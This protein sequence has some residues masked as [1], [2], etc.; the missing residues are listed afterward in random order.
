MVHHTRRMNHGLTRA[1]AVELRGITR[2]FPSSS[3]GG[4]GFYSHQWNSSLSCI[5]HL[6]PYAWRVWN[7]RRIHH[8]SVS[9]QAS[10]EQITCAAVRL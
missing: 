7:H 8:E 2:E 1:Q 3:Q 6:R 10:M 4:T 5:T 9:P